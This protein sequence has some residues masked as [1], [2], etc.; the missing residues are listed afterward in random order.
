MRKRYKRDYMILESKDP[1]FRLKEKISPKAF[2]K[3]ETKEEKVNIMIYVENVKYVKS[4]YRII[5]IQDDL[6]TKD[7]GRVLVNESGKGEFKINFDEENLDVKSI[8]LTHKNNI[9]LIGFKGKVI[10]NYEELINENTKIEESVVEDLNKEDEMETI[11]DPIKEK[12]EVEEEELERK[13][14][15]IELKQEE[16]IELKQE[17]AE[18]KDEVKNDK[19]KK[20][21]ET[22]YSQE[23]KREEK[24]D[25]SK[26]QDQDIDR[27]KYDQKLYLIPRKLKKLL[28]KHKEIKPFIKDIDNTRWWRI[29]VNPLTICSYIMPYLGYINY[30]NYTIYSDVTSLS[31]KYRHYIFGIKYSCDGKRKYYIYGIPGRRNEQPDEGDTGFCNFIPCDDKNKTYGYWICCIDCKSRLIA[32][33]DK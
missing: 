13:E 3:I 1:S 25:N 26:H 8:A 29:D 28:N 19:K 23:E 5:L 7:I 9:P 15:P 2:A 18:I 17:E 30:I 20:Q 4:G 24:I 14:E 6:T 10:D 16:P 21:E 33:P 12:T 27:K 31:Y 11:I 32:V 22:H